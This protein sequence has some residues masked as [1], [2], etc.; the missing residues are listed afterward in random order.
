MTG[1]KSKADATRAIHAATS[2]A[3][4]ANIVSPPVQRASTVILPDARSLYDNSQIS[5]GRKGLQPQTALTEALVELEG[6][7]SGQ[8]YPNGLSAM[9]GPMLALLQAGD[10]I[11]V[12][13]SIY[14]PTRRFCDRVLKRFGVTPQFFNPT[15]GLEEIAGLITDKT[16]MIVLE[17][18]GSLS[19]E[20]MDVPAI[21]KLAKSSGITTMID[22]TWSAGLLFKPLDHGIDISSQA[23]TKY[24]AGHSDV[25]M[26]FAC[27]RDP[28]LAR[29]LEE[30]VWHV[31][32]GASPD[33]AYLAMRGLRTLPT[34]MAQHGRNALA[35]AEWAAAQEGVTEVLCA[36]LPGAR[37]HDIWKRDFSGHNGLIG[38][39]LENSSDDSVYDF[40]DAL[41]L[42]RLGFS[43]GGYESLAINCDPQFA[44]RNRPPHFAGPLIRLQVGL[45]DVEDL[46]LD[47][48]SALEA[49]RNAARA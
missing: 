45:E 25:F 40:L 12:S 30:G 36:A 32:W 38:L 11:L 28:K 16:R 22:N 2:A 17:S 6:A 1:K 29:K 9:T 18:P 15:A 31:G 35:I 43:W 46:K 10:E 19:F 47:L 41:S 42:F 23:L 7:A 37:G 44:V 5:Y 34:R 4:V 27:T 39:V 26:G 13:D 21:A 8:L 3:P 48:A 24:V 14:A 20:F 49:W 33:D